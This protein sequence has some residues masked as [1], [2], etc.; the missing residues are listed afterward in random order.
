MSESQRDPKVVDHDGTPS[1]E[2]ENS[3]M[4]MSADDVVR[5][6]DEHLDDD[7]NDCSPEVF[8]AVDDSQA[9]RP[10]LGAED[11][12]D[13]A[14]MGTGVLNSPEQ[15]GH[16]GKD[17]L[18]DADTA[19]AHRAGDTP[20]EQQFPTGLDDDVALAHV[21][22]A[23]A[24]PIAS[25]PPR[26]A[27]EDAAAESTEIFAADPLTAELHNA[28]TIV[29][30]SQNLLLYP[31]SLL[32]RTWLA[33][34]TVA[35][36]DQKCANVLEQIVKVAEQ[37][38]A[39]VYPLCLSALQFDEVNR[40]PKWQQPP[41]GITEPNAMVH[42]VI[43]VSKALQIPDKAVAMRKWISKSFRTGN[44]AL[45]T[46]A[47]ARDLPLHVRFNAAAD[48]VGEAMRMIMA[49]Y[50]R[51]WTADAAGFSSFRQLMEGTRCPYDP[52]Q[53]YLELRAI[54][55]IASW[56]RWSP[57]AGVVSRSCP[58]SPRAES[59]LAKAAEFYSWS[60][61]HLK[62][63]YL[64][65]KDL[66]RQK[67]LGNLKWVAFGAAIV[68]F[69]ALYL[70]LT[71]P[72]SPSPA[73]D[74]AKCGGVTGEY[75][76]G[77]NFEKHILTRNDSTIEI[78]TNG[79]VAAGMP[80]DHFSIRW[81]GM[82]AFPEKGTYDLCVEGDDGVRLTFNGKLVIDD[83]NAH[84]A[85][86]NCA[87]VRVRKGWYPFKL[88]YFENVH[89]AVVRLLRRQGPGSYEGFK[90][91]ELC[92]KTPETKGP[93]EKQPSEKA[94]EPTLDDKTDDNPD[95]NQAPPDA[96]LP[97]DKPKPTDDGKPKRGLESDKV[98]QIKVVPVLK[99]QPPKKA[100]KP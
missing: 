91:S 62:R 72:Q 73:P 46:L 61:K 17:S 60:E 99:E 25:H 1:K 78:S 8:S 69:V 2:L 19:V 81:Q 4:P 27:S 89:A 83:W 12:H 9:L 49:A 33:I 66:Q 22:K 32:N 85:K 5:A 37:N 36:A 52:V 76:E 39:V 41:E 38:Q 59:L 42:D 31:V 48:L 84:P 26:Y 13:D 10:A 54:G 80:R 86:I 35:K 63:Q 64:T 21:A 20:Y 93:E 34:T 70:V 18:D 75:F 95:D 55:W 40:W 24:V 94:E 3:L 6:S 88:E 29:F 56:Y 67:L 57:Q 43:P 82:L 68:L 47:T 90:S 92:C 77:D 87:K 100:P 16:S 58:I 11:T 96:Q 23:V 44:L 65:K 30:G 7:S 53:N 71:W 28:Y 74:P 51:D 15:E 45:D 50:G 98:Q 79:S 14:I 97:T